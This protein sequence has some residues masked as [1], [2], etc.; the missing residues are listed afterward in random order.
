MSHIVKEKASR[1]F[2]GDKERSRQ[3][4]F[5]ARAT[6][7]TA[8]EGYVAMWR[9]TV[10]ET[11]VPSKAS[12]TPGQPVRADSEGE[13]RFMAELVAAGWLCLRS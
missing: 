10:W 4:T 7:P 11:S 3:T 2:T 6:H 8:G 5:G 13:T 9:C 12:S 1:A